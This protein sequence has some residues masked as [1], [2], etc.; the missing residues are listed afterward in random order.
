MKKFLLHK[1]LVVFVTGLAIMVFSVAQSEAGAKKKP[2]KI[3][4]TCCFIGPHAAMAGFC[5]A[6][7]DYYTYLNETQGGIMGH[8]IEVTLFGDAETPKEMAHYRSFAP[9]VHSISLYSTMANRALKKE[10]NEIDR[11]PTMTGTMDEVALGPYKFLVGPSYQK[12]TEVSLKRIA[13]LGGKKVAI[14]HGNFG[15][16]IEVPK[17]I[18]AKKIPE[19]LGLKIVD[20]V[21][22]MCN[23]ADITSEMARIKRHN[24]DYIWVWGAP[25][26]IHV[27]AALRL[28][29]PVKKLFYNHWITHGM[30]EKKFGKK[31]DGLLGWMMFPTVDMVMSH[32]DLPVAKELKEFFTNHKPYSRSWPYIR[33]WVIGRIRMEVIKRVLEKTGNVIPDDIHVFRDNIRDGFLNLKDY[34]LGIGHGLGKIDYSDHMGW[35]KMMPAIMKNGKWETG[36]YE[37]FK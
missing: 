37:S 26:G 30:I 11:I 16:M 27:A 19:K 15:W 7:K 8:P 36:Q 35:H 23:S 4:I 6:E 9:Y 2:I 21:E 34:D 10:V 24:P 33:G 13:K 25:P 32:P 3:A 31:A 22:Y 14:L 29:I 20:V 5:Y 17:Q 12:Q 1:V 18:I 28:G